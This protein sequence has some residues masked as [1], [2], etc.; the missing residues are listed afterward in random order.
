VPIV[1]DAAAAQGAGSEQSVNNRDVVVVDE[2]S[3]VDKSAHRPHADNENAGPNGSWDVAAAPA[4]PPGSGR[5]AAAESERCWASWH[6]PHG[7]SEFSRLSGGGERI[8][9]S[10][11]SPPASTSHDAEECATAS[12]REPPTPRRHASD[13]TRDHGAQKRVAPSQAHGREGPVP[14][15]KRPRLRSEEG[16]FSLGERGEHGH[17]MIEPATASPVALRTCNLSGHSHPTSVA[18]SRIAHV[19]QASFTDMITSFDVSLNERD[20][21][22]LT[23]QAEIGTLR[24]ANATLETRV[25]EQ[26]H[27]LIERDHQLIAR[28][29]EIER[30]RRKWAKAKKHLHACRRFLDDEDE[31]DKGGG[32]AV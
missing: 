23:N 31:S 2:S 1:A 5:P 8:A 19:A 27:L 12:S 3:S 7:S 10:T 11:T 21:Q 32:V 14:S 30:L 28:Q 17:E 9:T 4:R 13:G 22:L 16:S 20:Q 29:E 18:V 15:P 6:G 25:R 26:D 24:A